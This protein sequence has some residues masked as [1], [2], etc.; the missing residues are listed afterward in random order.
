M[1]FA[2][3][4]A[5]PAVLLAVAACESIEYEPRSGTVAYLE[6]EEAEPWVENECGYTYDWDG[7]YRYSCWTDSGVDPECW[8]VEFEDPDGH[9]W[10]DC[11]TEARWNDLAVGDAYTED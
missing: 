4:V 10:E 3:A 6:Y 8:L 2:L 7:R 9:V 1:R 11:T 5:A